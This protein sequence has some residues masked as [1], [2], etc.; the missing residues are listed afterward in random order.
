[1]QAGCQFSNRHFNPI[2]EGYLHAAV[3][4]DRHPVNR[5]APKFRREN[6]DRLVIRQYSVPEGF[7]FPALSFAP[8]AFRVNLLDP[9]R[10][11]MEALRQA[12]VFSIILY[13]PQL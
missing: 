10:S 12:V 4:I 8:S 5:R 1:M 9:I 13:R 11:F 7:D 2:S 6:R 3:Q